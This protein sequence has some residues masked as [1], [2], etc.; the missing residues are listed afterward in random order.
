MT[1]PSLETQ[2][3]LLA[4]RGE[5]AACSGVVSALPFV[6]AQKGVDFLLWIRDTSLVQHCAESRFGFGL[7]CPGVLPAFPLL[8][9]RLLVTPPSFKPRSQLLPFQVECTVCLRVVPALPLVAPQKGVDLL[10]W[11]CDS[12]LV[13][14]CAELSFGFGLGCPGVLPAFPLLSCRLLVTPPS[15]ETQVEL[16]ALRGEFAACS[17]VVSAFPFVAVQKSADFLL[18]IRDTSLVQHC[19]ESR[20]G[21]GLGCPGVLPAFPLLGCRL[22]VASESFELQG[23]LLALHGEFAACSGV[24]SALPFVAAQKGV[25]FLLCIRDTSLVQRCAKSRFGFG[26]G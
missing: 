11:I 16:L 26:L 17:R 18:C 22:L 23:E 13:Q 4:L 21:F 6:A 7:G 24:V 2:V 19:A 3:E 15:L 10:L 14:H 25:D 8:G 20:L 5:F 12:S 9:C 1:S